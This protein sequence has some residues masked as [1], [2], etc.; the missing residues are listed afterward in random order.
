DR[1]FIVGI[2]NDI[3]NCWGFTFPK[4]LNKRLK[5]YDIIPGIEKSNFTKKKFPPEVLFN[6]GKFDGAYISFKSEW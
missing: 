2:R 6:D 1:I 4:P 5:L 3:A